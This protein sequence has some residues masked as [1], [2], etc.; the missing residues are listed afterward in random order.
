MDVKGEGRDQLGDLP[1]SRKKRGTRVLVSPQFHVKHDAL[2]ETTGLK[3]GRFGLPTSCWQVLAGFKKGTVSVTRQADP[4]ETL[5]QKLKRPSPAREIG[6]NIVD[7]PP[8]NDGIAT[9]DDAPVNNMEEATV[10]VQSDPGDEEGGCQSTRV[11]QQIWLQ[12]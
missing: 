3:V 4:V 8:T 6:T 9:N 1:D 5:T 11:N 7:N 12:R 10:M 2:F